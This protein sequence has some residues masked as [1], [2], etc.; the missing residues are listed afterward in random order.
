MSDTSRAYLFQCEGEDLC[1]AQSRPCPHI[2]R[3]DPQG[4]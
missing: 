1:T 2:G 4:N 3:T